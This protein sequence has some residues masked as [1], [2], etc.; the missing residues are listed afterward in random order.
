MNNLKNYKDFIN[1]ELVWFRNFNKESDDFLD[2]LDA[3]IAGNKEGFSNAVNNF[4]LQISS[5]DRPT[6]DIFNGV[7]NDEFYIEYFRIGQ[8]RGIPYEF[9]DF[10]EELIRKNCERIFPK[11]LY[12]GVM[13]EMNDGG[14]MLREYT[15]GEAKEYLDSLSVERGKEKLGTMLKNKGIIKENKSETKPPKHELIEVGMYVTIPSEIDASRPGNHRLKV[16]SIENRSKK[17]LYINP[18]TLEDG[19][20][21]FGSDCFYPSFKKRN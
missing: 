9:D 10:K 6:P 2:L 20:I 3:V 4:V 21:Y 8:Q 18:V 5:G 12:K 19:S 17:F 1:E 14:S 16:I 7:I 15:T 11:M 13:T